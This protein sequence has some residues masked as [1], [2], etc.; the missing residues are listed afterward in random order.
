MTSQTRQRRYTSVLIFHGLA[1]EVVP[2][3]NAEALYASMQSP[4]KMVLHDGGDH[5]MTNRV[6]QQD[7]EQKMIAW[8]K[9]VLMQSGTM[10]PQ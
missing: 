9:S 5:Q 7:F 3:E 2:V 1:D 10:C 6:H 4:K 8:Y